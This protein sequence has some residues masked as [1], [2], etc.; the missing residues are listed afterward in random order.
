MNSGRIRSFY[1]GCI[2]VGTLFGLV[3]PRAEA[4]VPR[5]PA[6][7]PVVRVRITD[8]FREAAVGGFDLRIASLA[9]REGI[10]SVRPST[11]LQN[12]APAGQSVQRLVADARSSW[13]IECLPSGKIRLTLDRA[14]PSVWVAETPLRIEALSGFLKWDG[15]TYRDEIWIHNVRTGGGAKGLEH[16]ECEAVNHVGIEKYLDGLV[17]GE[18]SASWPAATIDAQVVA[19]RTYAYYSTREAAQN[20]A[21]HYDLDSSTKDQVYDGSRKEDQRSALSAERTRGQILT[22][23]G[24]KVPLKA[25]YS[26]TCGGM[27]ELP[28][29]V[30]GKASPGINRRVRCDYCKRSPT[31]FW[32][33]KFADDQILSRLLRVAKSLLLP[34]PQFTA[35]SEIVKLETSSFPNSERIDSVRIDLKDVYRNLSWVFP[36]NKLRIGLDPVQLK[37]TQFK[38]FALNRDEFVFRGKGYGHGVGM[39][40]WGA[41]TM[42]ELGK[43]SREI[44]AFYYPDAD[45]YRA[46]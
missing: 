39:C 23:H 14:K 24:T 5:T 6:E 13:Q 25:Y 45:L 33:A 31:Y 10:L 38:V 27:T 40:Q 46:W 9:H 3:I 2:F 7:A 19:A 1:S 15:H 26:S 22:P 42:G 11:A 28:E 36:A 20:P 16:V 35:S 43:R 41:K 12:R 8:S 30:W 18:I 34:F 29:N 37:S 4:S 44:L 17:N 21:R 32:E